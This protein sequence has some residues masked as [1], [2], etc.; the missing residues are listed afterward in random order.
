MVQQLSDED[1]RCCIDFCLHSQ[2]LMSSDDHFLAK[3][4][5]SDEATFHVW[6]AVPPLPRDLTDLKAWIIATVKNIDAPTLTHVWQELEY[7]MCAMSPTVH[8]SNISSCQNKLFQFSC[9]CEQF[10]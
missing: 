10:H 1:H 2:D 7:H 9:G 8:T 6:G 3:V 5:F 4:L